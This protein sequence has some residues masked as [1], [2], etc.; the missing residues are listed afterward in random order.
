MVKI[1]ILNA[2]PP[3]VSPEAFNAHKNDEPS[4]EHPKIQ[5]KITHN[6]FL[7]LALTG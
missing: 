7:I 3:S 6:R 1:I 2:A 5:D 4:P